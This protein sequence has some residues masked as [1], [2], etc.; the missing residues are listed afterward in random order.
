MVSDTV[1]I[2]DGPND[3]RKV[4]RK[5]GTCSRTFFHILNREFGHPKEWEEEASGALAGGIMQQGEQCGMLWGA[6]LAIG[7][8][9]YRSCKTK[10]EAIATAIIATQH[11]MNS[12]MER[13]QTIQCKEITRC[14]FGNKWSYAKYMITGRFLHCFKMAQEWAPQAVRS[15][16]AG[17]TDEEFE[18][19]RTAMSCATEVAKRMGS[20]EEH[21]TMVAG[22]AGGLGLSG[23][24]CGALAAAVWMK[25]LTRIKGEDEKFQ[26][27]N[28]DAKKTLEV[29]YKTTNNNIVCSEIASELFNDIDEHTQFLENGGCAH[30]IKTLA[31]S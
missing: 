23:G 10:S 13:E 17:L 14:D 27:Q 24:G 8:E 11:V 18:K 3:G 1:N 25:S 20:S 29:F 4:F 6:S 7:A 15:A 16:Q 26:V 31:E 9:A 21:M 30:L 28:Q 19:H 5:L 2:A 12:F 22:F